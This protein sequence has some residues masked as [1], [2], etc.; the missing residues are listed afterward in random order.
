MGKEQHPRMVT[1]EWFAIPSMPLDMALL[2]FADLLQLLS[3]L[4]HTCMSFRYWIYLPHVAFQEAS[5]ILTTIYITLHSFI[6]SVF[7]ACNNTS[8]FVSS[9]MLVF[10]NCLICFLPLDI[11]YYLHV[12]TNTL[13]L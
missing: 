2:G 13:F 12:A 8:Q 6:A 5:P 11:S 4:H 3:H 9:Y 1:F 10:S 7:I